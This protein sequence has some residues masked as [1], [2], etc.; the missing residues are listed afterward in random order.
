MFVAIMV[1]RS[2][3]MM[4]VLR[5]GEGGQ[6]EEDTDH[7]QRHSPTEQTEEA[8]G[9]YRQGHHDV[10]IRYLSESASGADGSRKY[11]DHGF[12]VNGYGLF[13]SDSLSL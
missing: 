2:Q 7:S 10:R 5:H 12:S 3:L 4:D 11:A 6:A 13:P 8:Y 1:G 9:L